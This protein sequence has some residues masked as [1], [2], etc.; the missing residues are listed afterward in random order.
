M[1]YHLLVAESVKWY[2][3]GLERSSLGLASISPMIFS[4]GTGTARGKI[5][6][7]WSLSVPGAPK[8]S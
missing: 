1:L 2:G 6:K 4:V 5:E 8:P 7:L 3:L